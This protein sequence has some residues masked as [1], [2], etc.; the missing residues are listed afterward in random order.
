VR[1][2]GM[3]ECANSIKTTCTIEFVWWLLV[4]CKHLLI[5]WQWGEAYFGKIIEC[6]L[7]GNG[8]QV[9]V[10][11]HSILVFNK[12]NKKIDEKEYIKW[13]KEFDLGY[14]KPMVEHAMARDRAIATYKV[15]F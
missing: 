7:N 11:M 4:L 1:R 9:P 15:E 6:N 3:Q 13:I 2:C 5:E 12:F 14:G 8:Q 10:V